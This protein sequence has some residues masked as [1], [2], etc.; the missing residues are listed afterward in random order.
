MPNQCPIRS[1]A[2]QGGKQAQLEKAC[3]E[4]RPDLN[5]SKAKGKAGHSQKD[6]FPTEATENVLAPPL[7]KPRGKAAAAAAKVDFFFPE[8][9]HNPNSFVQDKSSQAS[10]PRPCAPEPPLQGPSAPSLQI[11]RPGSQFGFSIGDA[12]AA[13]QA[14][15]A[16]AN[17]AQD[18]PPAGQQVPMNQALGIVPFF[19]Q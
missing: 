2:G 5:S 10:M 17:K 18:R 14:A 6:T 8:E 12:D 15:V 1:T 7:P 4:I 16:L 19:T 11:S 13:K 3:D 9:L